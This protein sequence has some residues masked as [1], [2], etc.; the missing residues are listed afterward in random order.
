MHDAVAAAFSNPARVRRNSR[1][2]AVRACSCCR[3]HTSAATVYGS[4]ACSGADLGYLLN[5]WGYCPN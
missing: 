3:P 4:S 5:A 1:S 2:S